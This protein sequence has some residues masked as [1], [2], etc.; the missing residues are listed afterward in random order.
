MN[1]KMKILEMV[2]NG[3]LTPEEAAKLLSAVEKNE[4]MPQIKA[5]KR[6][7]Q[8]FKIHIISSEGDK[9]NVQIPLEFAKI[10]MR[11]QKHSLLISHA[12]LNDMNM[13]IDWD[14]IMKMIN[15]GV[16]GELVNI[17]SADGDIVRIVI[18]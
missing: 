14:M 18:E 4:T 13:D 5:S 12:K 7:S 6:Y 9:V 15:E 2:E 16:I 8:M 17:E 3:T 1:E 10:A 11:S